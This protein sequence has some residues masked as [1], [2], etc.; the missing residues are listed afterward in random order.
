MV[1]MKAQEKMKIGIFQ[2]NIN[3]YSSIDSKLAKLEDILNR[4]I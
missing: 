4:M 2:P 1:F 3:N